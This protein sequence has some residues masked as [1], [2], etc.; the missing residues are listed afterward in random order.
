MWLAAQQRAMITL[1]AII[2]PPGSAYLVTT[3]VPTTSIEQKPYGLLVPQ[4]GDI[5]EQ[6]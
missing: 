5:T 4:P 2:E 6:R 1:G 3:I